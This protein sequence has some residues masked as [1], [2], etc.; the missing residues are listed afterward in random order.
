MIT[1]SNMMINRKVMLK[2]YKK[3]KMS[4]SIRHTISLIIQRKFNP[5]MMIM[6]I[7]EPESQDKLMIRREIVMMSKR[8]I[9][10]FK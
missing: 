7:R 4:I 10:M 1:I 9:K 5:V 2:I 3:S 8:I 6:L